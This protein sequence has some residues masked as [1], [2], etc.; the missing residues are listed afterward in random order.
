MNLSSFVVALTTIIAADALSVSTERRVLQ[1]PAASSLMFSWA[2]G[3]LGKATL[4]STATSSKS[5][6]ERQEGQEGQEGQDVPV[7]FRRSVRARR[8][9]KRDEQRRARAIFF[10]EKQPFQR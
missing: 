7:N 9:S 8:R 3:Y 4:C 10:F 1:S 2:R 5:K 6:Q